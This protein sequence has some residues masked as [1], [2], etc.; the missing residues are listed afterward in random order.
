M[1]TR[2]T[3]P[4]IGR[5]SI[6]TATI[7]L[8]FA[9]T[10]LV[11][12]PVQ[13]ISFP[14]FGILIDFVIDFTTVVVIFTVFLAAFGMDWIIQTHPGKDRYQ[15]RWEFFR[16]M[17]VPVLTSFVIGITLNA[18]AGGVTWWV[19]YSLGSLLLFAVFI[20][21]YNVLVAEDYRNPLATIGLSSL[22][23]VLYLLLAIAVYSADI[24]LYLRASLL[25]I[26]SLMVISRAL[27]LRVGKWHMLWAIV[28]SIIV[29][30][31]VVGFHY[32]PLSPLRIGVLITGI[33]Y[34]LSSI[35][36]G[37]KEKR[38]AWAFWG[39]PISMMAL[40]VLASVFLR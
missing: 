18:F 30:E 31:I 38:T 13:S 25:G 17:I 19:V 28:C 34:T 14:L 3:L 20:A 6:V 21:E 33:V 29:S 36:S 8:S 16:H 40:V 26:G 4:D 5:L 37:L 2:S 7:M 23:F 39:E 27:F 24:R 1:E 9:L 35:V 32:L 15:N 22:S 12:F 10:Q 11:T